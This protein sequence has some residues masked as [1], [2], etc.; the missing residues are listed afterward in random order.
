M[1]PYTPR[2]PPWVGDDPFPPMPFRLTFTI[3]L[4]PSPSVSGVQQSSHISIR[5]SDLSLSSG[6]L[7][8][9][10][11]TS[12]CR[13]PRHLRVNTL[14]GKGNGFPNNLRP[15]PWCPLLR[16]GATVL[17]LLCSETW[18]SALIVH[19][20]YSPRSDQTV[21]LLFSP[22]LH[23]DVPPPPPSHLDAVAAFSPSFQSEVL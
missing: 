12:F 22:F 21:R 7:S 10:Y 23:V 4:P 8:L 15:C 6:S 13:P 17:H 20:S 3:S 11:D 18:A 2:P 16:D 14:Q 1:N 9:Q 19:V 5:S